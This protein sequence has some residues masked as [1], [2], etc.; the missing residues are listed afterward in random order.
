MPTPD[1][2]PDG[3]DAYDDG[4][5]E[6]ALQELDQR[7]EETEQT[8]DELANATSLISQEQLSRRGVEKEVDTITADLESQ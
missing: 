7:L 4:D 5:P 1:D 3:P 2:T 8:A 6:E